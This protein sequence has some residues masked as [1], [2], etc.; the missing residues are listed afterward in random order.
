M[1]KKMI[2]FILVAGIL[3]GCAPSTPIVPT[4]QAPVAT[5][6]PLPT[7]TQPPAPTDTP[8]PLTTPIGGSSLKVA[9]AGSGACTPGTET[10]LVIADF[11]SGR[12]DFRIP[13]HSGK[14]VRI[15]WS[16]DGSHIIYGD[17]VD[18]FLKVMLL[19]VATHAVTILG[20]YSA[21]IPGISS[22]NY[23]WQAT[24]SDDGNY[25]FYQTA[26]NALN[27]QAY[28]ASMENPAP[29]T[30][31]GYPV[32]GVWLPGTHTLLNLGK[33]TV[34]DLDTGTETKI[35]A[36]SIWDARI[37]DGLLTYVGDG[38]P[39]QPATLTMVP[40]PES[41]NEPANI[42]PDIL[43]AGRVPLAR[44]SPE[45]KDGF[46][47]P[48]A[49]FVLPVGDKILLS[50]TLIFDNYHSN[51]SFTK[52]L[53]R[54]ALPAAIDA[55]D[56]NNEAV[57]TVA[58]DRQWYLTADLTLG[59]GGTRTWKLVFH[60]FQSQQ[61]IMPQFDLSQFGGWNFTDQAPIWNGA[62]DFYWER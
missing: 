10:C 13:L 11:F 34:F 17:Q 33:Q 12:I 4:T 8:T 41:L 36:E 3:A 14:L 61:A 7:L 45:L 53:D 21:T 9:F 52:M 15:A 6:T 59:T 49:P 46:F 29:R 55:V 23:L 2:V 30:F 62:M 5:L 40:L 56:F 25:V 16:P 37:I 50:G 51:G 26:S 32:A 48:S 39:S 18:E 1:L 20:T 31:D 22:S 24:W 28:L 57:L 35:M 54:A 60:D 43:L 44:I 47:G 58:P 19:D 42:N 27:H 38:I